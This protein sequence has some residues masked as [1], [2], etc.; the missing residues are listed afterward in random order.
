MIDPINGSPELAEAVLA[1]AR[2]CRANGQQMAS[3]GNVHFIDVPQDE[4]TKERR[5]KWRLQDA[6][7]REDRNGLITFHSEAFREGYEHGLGIKRHRLDTME[8]VDGSQAWYFDTPKFYIDVERDK[9]L[10]YSVFFRNRA[11]Q[12][13]AW[14]DQADEEMP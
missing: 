1:I 9:D 2:W 14:L 11:D 13:E 5:D 12:S 7:C 6:A 10:K 8:K 3:F 4:E